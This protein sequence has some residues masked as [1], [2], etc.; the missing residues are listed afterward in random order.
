MSPAR[1]TSGFL[2]RVDV[3][4]GLGLVGAIGG[5][6]VVLMSVFFLVS[7]HDTVEIL[8]SVLQH[9]LD[10]AGASVAAGDAV[11][12]SAPSA[13]GAI[14]IRRVDMAGGAELL[15]GAWPT[16]GR[17][18][19]AGSSTLRLA[20]AGEADHLVDSRRLP[21]GGQLEA[22]LSLQGFAHERRE[23]V[24]RILLSLAST[25]IG[26]LV[27]AWLA[28]RLA[29]APLRAATSAVEG[30]DERHLDAR[31][32]VRGTGDDLDR[33]ARA[34]NHVLQRLEDAFQ[35]TSAFSADVAHELRTPVNRM[36]NLADVALLRG[37]DGEAAP[38]LVA[39]REAAEDM[40]RLIEN[41]LLLSKGDE[42]RLALRREPVS[43]A[44]LTSDL[45]ELFHPTCEERTIDLSLLLPPDDDKVVGDRS[46][47]QRAISNLLDN[48]IRHT[49]AGG[50]IEVSV[51]RRDEAVEI[52]VADSGRGVAERDHER[53]FDRFVQLDEARAGE[54]V[55]LGLALVRM[56]ARL[57]GGDVTLSRSALG[58]ACFRMTLPLAPGSGTRAGGR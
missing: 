40:R 55:G 45:L 14:A 58:G 10:A 13:P 56:I 25:G 31:L 11:P 57:Q 17:A 16:S 2:R 28:T 8:E 43:L 44:E 5:L 37:S 38:D 18:F 1:N 6:L 12:E 49:P 50:K 42:G 51:L 15:R 23:Q 7:T 3:S 41:L 24:G 32:P 47:L 52:A 20:F 54:G 30:I 36:L 39:V 35:R 46:L 4:L 9:E 33:H 27:V 22:V 53:V 34:L 19:H 26:L 48:A 29:L 21:G